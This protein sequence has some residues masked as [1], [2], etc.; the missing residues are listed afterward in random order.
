LASAI[1][2]SCHPGAA[3]KLAE[4]PRRVIGADARLAGK[5]NA[6][7]GSDRDGGGRFRSHP[8]TD[9]LGE[10][11]AANED[12]ALEQQGKRDPGS[13]DDVL[14]VQVAERNDDAAPT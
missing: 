2:R 14:A 1:R 13:F 8:M 5:A 9:T 3:A 11:A 12:Q 7:G 6:R 10:H 4:G